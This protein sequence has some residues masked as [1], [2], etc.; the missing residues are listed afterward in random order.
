MSGEASYAAPAT[1]LVVC[2]AQAAFFQLDIVGPVNIYT[3][4]CLGDW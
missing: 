2:Y 3:I 1:K 4:P